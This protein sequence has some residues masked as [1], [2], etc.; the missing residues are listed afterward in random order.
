MNTSCMP[1]TDGILG[2]D[3]KIYAIPQAASSVLVVDTAKKSVSFY[4][5]FGLEDHEHW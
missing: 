2:D 4:E 5:Q 1:C 3:G